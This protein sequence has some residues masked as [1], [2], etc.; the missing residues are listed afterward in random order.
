ME[1][2]FIL[3]IIFIGKLLKLFL[4]IRRLFFNG[5]GGKMLGIVFDVVSSFMVELWV[6]IFFWVL[7]RLFII[8][9][10]GI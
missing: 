10:S 5:I 1:F 4:L 7:L 6:K 2:V 8:M 9:C 3:C